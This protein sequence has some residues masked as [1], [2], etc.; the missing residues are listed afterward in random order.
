M[1]LSDWYYS[2]YYG[3]GGFIVCFAIYLIIKYIWR[4]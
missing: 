1:M 2:L 3:V 4:D